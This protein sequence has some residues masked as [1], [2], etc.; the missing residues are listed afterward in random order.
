MNILKIAI[1]QPTLYWEQPLK[2]IENLTILISQI[3]E[4]THL[5][6]LP[7]MFNTG[8]SLRPETFS[9]KMDG[10]TISWLKKVSIDTNAAIT[11]SLMIE[12]SGKYFNRLVWVEDGEVEYY[13]DKRHLFS[14]V[15]EDVP[16]AAG[17]E[18][19]IITYKNW[20]IAP[21]ICYDLRFPAWCRNTEDVDIQ[22]YVANWPEKRN[23]HW[24]LLLQAR[25]IENQCFVIASNRVGEDL[26]GNNHSGD[27]ALIDYSG[28]TKFLA[29]N[30][31][32]IKTFEVNKT[33]LEEYRK[34]YPFHLEKDKFKFEE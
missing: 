28:E 5:I 16:F 12:E 19:V 30:L 17:K 4:N 1:V 13:Y 18:K 15:G 20:K 27:S 6:V 8:F 31:Q 9:E 11:G 29:S 23:H 2:N 34:R 10:L 26:W 14:L 32:A 24:K 33:D 25:A 22:L 3:E 21:F 7:E